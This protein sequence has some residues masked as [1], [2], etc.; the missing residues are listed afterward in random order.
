MRQTCYGFRVHVRLVWPGVTMRVCIAPAHVHELEA[1]S[2]LAEG[3]H[4]SPVRD[5]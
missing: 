2:G 3:T 1:P 4:G 5:Q